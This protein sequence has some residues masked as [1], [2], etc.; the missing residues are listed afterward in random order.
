[1]TTIHVSLDDLLVASTSVLVKA[2]AEFREAQQRKDQDIVSA[3]RERSSLTDGYWK[4]S[5][6]ARLRFEAAKGFYEALMFWP[7]EDDAGS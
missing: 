2:E 6:V 5:H 4:A 3:F 1:M 7:K